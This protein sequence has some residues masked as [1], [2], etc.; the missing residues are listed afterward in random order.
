MKRP[1]VSVLMPVYNAEKTLERSL[2]SLTGQTLEDIEIIL[3]DD[4]STDG[5]PE[6]I[7]RFAE[8]D[9]RIRTVR[10]KNGGVSA[11]RNRALEMSRGT[12]IG[13]CDADD[14]VAPAYYETLLGMVD[15]TEA[16]AAVCEFAESA[17][18]AFVF[19]PPEEKKTLM[20]A[21]EALEKLTR[22]EGGFRSYLW[23]KLYRRELFEGI[24]FPEERRNEDQFV[25]WRVLERAEYV[26][27]MPWKG[28]CYF[29]LP[30]SLTNG[31]WDTLAVDYLEAWKEIHAFC[32][33]EY[34][35]LCANTSDQIVSAAI[36]TLGWL[37]K[38]GKQAPEL[39]EAMRRAVKEYGR[40]YGRSGIA[41]VTA[42]RKLAA[43]LIR[44]SLL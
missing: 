30:E 10:V 1:L 41:P 12:W 36:Y 28:Y 24:R 40:E 3:V 9:G 4:G 19:D 21:G 29:R 32:E 25:T 17:E 34:P 14:T 35:A 39:R 44:H 13:F 20:T 15:G 26:A 37:K 43:F 7:R 2:R 22:G 6:I 38:Q 42:K 5:S 31:K 33:K 16:K 18:E 11:A 8:E 23:N 27:W